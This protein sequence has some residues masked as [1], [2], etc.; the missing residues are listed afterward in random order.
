MQAAFAAQR[1]A[2]CQLTRLS[3]QGLEQGWSETEALNRMAVQGTPDAQRQQR[4]NL[5]R[6]WRE[7]EALWLVQ[8]PFPLACEAVS[9]PDV[10]R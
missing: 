3:W 2:L 1:E 8:A 10:G 7:M 9:A 4:F 5:L 6:A